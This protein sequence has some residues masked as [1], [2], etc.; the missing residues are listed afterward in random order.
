M[1]MNHADLQKTLIGAAGMAVGAALV[2]LLRVAAVD[3]AENARTQ[4]L[5]D[6]AS[7]RTPMPRVVA[8]ADLDCPN[9]A[10]APVP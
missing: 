10:S 2:A 9:V 4:H 1:K 6:V 7:G 8:R 5:A 3:G